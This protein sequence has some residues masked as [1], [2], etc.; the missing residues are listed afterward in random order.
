MTGMADV[1]FGFW[2][3]PVIL[4]IIIPLIMLFGW[5]IG[6]L[7]MPNKRI[8]N[9]AAEQEDQVVLSEIFAKA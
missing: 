5:I 1:V 4:N 2:F 3:L 6:R 8:R 9:V 7:I